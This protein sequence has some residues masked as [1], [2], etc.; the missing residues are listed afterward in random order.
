MKNAS[1]NM[2]DAANTSFTVTAPAVTGMSV[3]PA[4]FTSAGGNAT[5]A[6]TGSNLLGQT[7]SIFLDGAEAA[8][9][10]V[11]SPSRASGTI[12]F[13]PNTTTS[14]QTHTITVY[15][16]GAALSG[17]SAA[18]T[19]SRVPGSYTSS[20]SRSAIPEPVIDNNGI[21]L[22]PTTIDMTKPSVTLEVTP[23]DGVAYISIPATILTSIEGKNA[24]FFIE[25]KTPYG[26]YQVPV[27]LASLIPGLEDLLD[28]NNLQAEDISFNIV[29]TNKS[30]DKN[31]QTA[32]SNGLPNGKVMGAAVDFHIDIFNTKTGQQIG[33]AD[34]FDKALTR[35]IPMPKDM[36]VIP[37]QWGAFRYNE[38][39]Q[40]FEFV[41][42]KKVEIDG[43]WCMMISSYSNSV[44]VVAQ[45]AVSYTDVQKHWSQSF[46]ELAAAKGLVEGV[47]G[48]LYNPDQSVTRAEFTAMLVRA[49]GRGTTTSS[50]AAYDDVKQGVWYFDV[51]T[52]AKELG[53]LGLVKGSRFMPDQPL[54]REEMAS[55]LAAALALEKLPLSKE[56]TNMDGYKDI[57][58]VDA[59][60]LDDVRTIVTL[61]IMTGTD[62]DTFSP[63]SETTRAQAAVVFIRTLQTL[64]LIDK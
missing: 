2:L 47:G 20:S 38:T 9:A 52:K 6:V 18:V 15:L 33:T 60:Y 62:E 37:V 39:A 30:G 27:N 3:T 21:S 40:K 12:V 50:I 32:L 56:F 25:I 43:V 23:K 61:Q 14:D 35:I 51:V 16:N 34:Q 24:S 17:E 53:L 54:T 29:L 48:G 59:T 44:Y 8:T 36:S 7:V 13:P 58:S 10:N 5:V 31:I 28:Q 41:A 1:N 4:S 46:V 55:M 42:A 19:V 63:K 57:N 64:G 22:N 49:L 11:S 45:N 26:S